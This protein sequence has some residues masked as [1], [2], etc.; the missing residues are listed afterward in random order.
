MDRAAF[1][2][3][4]ILFAALALEAI[5]DP[6]PPAAR[7][8]R[9]IQDLRREVREIQSLINRTRPEDARGVLLRIGEE[10]LP[11]IQ[12][13]LDLVEAEV[14][15]VA[16][17]SLW[18][19]VV[20]Q[21]DGSDIVVSVLGIEAGGLAVGAGGP[22]LRWDPDAWQLRD[23]EPA[24]GV[25]LICQRCDGGELRFVALLA[26]AKSGELLRI[27]GEGKPV[28]WLPNRE[29]IQL[30]DSENK[31]IDFVVIVW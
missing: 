28:I 30:V 21:V 15:K 23:L 12:A 9:L 29:H 5:V 17:L 20:F 2:F 8:A 18:P 10:H 16:Q 4:T 6:T 26:R 22:G 31:R 27:H 7:L 3:L 14:A 1:L 24:A 13:K 11:A 19:A 25:E